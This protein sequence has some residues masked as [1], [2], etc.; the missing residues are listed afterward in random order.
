MSK[1]EIERESEREIERESEVDFLVQWFTV[2]D[3]LVTEGHL[4]RTGAE[5]FTSS[6]SPQLI[7][8]T[9]QRSTKSLN[10]VFQGS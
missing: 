9:T 10:A 4:G 2:S 8:S 1:V 5:R 7:F 6:Q 3:D